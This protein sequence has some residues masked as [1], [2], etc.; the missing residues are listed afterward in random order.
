MA[1]NIGGKAHG[2]LLSAML[3]AIALFGDDIIRQRLS[4]RREIASILS[5]YPTAHLKY[6][7][8]HKYF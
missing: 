7:R 1:D 5:C 6:N 8:P 3:S 2:P 4:R